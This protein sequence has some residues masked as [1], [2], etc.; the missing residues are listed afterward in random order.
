MTTEN[1][2]TPGDSPTPRTTAWSEDDSVLEAVD[3]V[4]LAVR[5]AH[6]ADPVR[7]EVVLV[8]GLGEHSGR[9]GHVAQV[10]AKVL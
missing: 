10:L 3:G 7:A 9:Y 1:L 4:L 8:H 6:V 2:Y 5:S